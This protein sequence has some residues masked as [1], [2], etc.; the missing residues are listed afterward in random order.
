MSDYL[1]HYGVKGMKWGVR[2]DPE[3]SI[4]RLEKKAISRNYKRQL[5][6]GGHRII[7]KYRKSTGENYEKA[8]AKF[9]NIV[10]KDKKYKELSR[11]A[12]DAEKKK[13]LFEKQV[14][15]EDGNIKSKDKYRKY[16]ELDKVSQKATAAKEK[17]VNE[18]AK[19]YVDTI[20]SAKLKDLGITQNN[21]EAKKYISS[22]FDDYYFDNNLEW[23]PDN[24]YD[25]SIEKLKFK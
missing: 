14:Y 5:K 10:A 3:R 6:N 17:R 25:S 16:L 15:D 4:S 19:S 13:L 7:K 23:N 12:F 24:Y 20:K 1:I 11:A 8:N 22:K 21:A 9:Q 2:K 18:L